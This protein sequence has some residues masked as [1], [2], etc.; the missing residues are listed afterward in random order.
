[1][2]GGGALLAC[3]AIAT[4][5]PTKA[6]EAWAA[7]IPAQ[8]AAAHIPGL[9]LGMAKRGRIVFAR[10]YGFADL[11]RRRPK[12]A[13]GLEQSTGLERAADR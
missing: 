7:A 6:G 5:V 13:P 9:A 11:E 12:G 10:G 2:L 3:A 4:P 1:M 8:L